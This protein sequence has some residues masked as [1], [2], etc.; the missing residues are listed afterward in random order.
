[1]IPRCTS[2]GY[3]AAVW[4]NQSYEDNGYWDKVGC[5]GSLRKIIEVGEGTLVSCP[6]CYSVFIDPD[7]EEEL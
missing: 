7:Y 1:M 2:C 3:E 4:V 5:V 6:C